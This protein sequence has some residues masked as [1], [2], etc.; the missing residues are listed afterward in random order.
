MKKLSLILLFVVGGSVSQVF[1]QIDW[2]K[3]KNG[4][5]PGPIDQKQLESARR[6]GAAKA[7]GKVGVE[8][9]SNAPGTL[10]AIKKAG[11]KV[12]GAVKKGISATAEAVSGSAA[13]SKSSTE[14]AT[15]AIKAMGSA[16]KGAV[17]TVGDIVKGAQSPGPIDQK[18]L[19]L[20]KKAAVEAAMKAK[21]GSQ[22]FEIAANPLAKKPGESSDAKALNLGKVVSLLEQFNEKIVAERLSADQLTRLLAAMQAAFN[23]INE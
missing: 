10:D 7:M 11:N 13:V 8:L 12:A 14:K 16:A 1:A 21:A 6:A 2:A 17:K 22:D 23:I 4:G 20:G 3:L 19:A 15:S 18:Q 5:N 9:E